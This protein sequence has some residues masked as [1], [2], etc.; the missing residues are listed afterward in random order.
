VG[1][2]I[3]LVS[4]PPQNVTKTNIP[5]GEQSV[6]DATLTP[7]KEY[8]ITFCAGNGLSVQEDGSFAKISAEQFAASI[9][10]DRRTLYRWRDTIPEFGKRVKDRRR[11]IFN[12]NRESM[13]WNGLFLRAA[14]GDHKQAEMILSH[15]SDYTPP[16]QK[17][18]VKIGGLADLA[19]L[20]R[21][22]DK[23]IDATSNS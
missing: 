15:F 17:H 21:Q 12:A 22:K 6:V 19:K 16:T 3:V 9:G 14:K 8:Y 7:A 4:M 2:A 10:V 11:E 20:A 23:V 5:T 1:E 13:V 18:E